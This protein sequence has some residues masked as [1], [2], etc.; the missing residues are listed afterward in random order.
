MGLG[1]T[2]N[3]LITIPMGFH[4]SNSSTEGKFLLLLRGAAHSTLNRNTMD[5][6]RASSG[7][8]GRLHFHVCGLGG[9]LRMGV[10]LHVLRC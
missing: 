4:V 8:R 6:S 9:G 5:R 1:T 7:L 2:E 10:R 3:E